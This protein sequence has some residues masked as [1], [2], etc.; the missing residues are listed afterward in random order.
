MARHP[1]VSHLPAVLVIVLS[2]RRRGKRSASPDHD[3]LERVL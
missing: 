1:S 2:R 3:P